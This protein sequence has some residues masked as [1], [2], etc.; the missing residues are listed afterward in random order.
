V[1][2]APRFVVAAATEQC[3]DSRM[4]RSLL[5]VMALLVV[6][7]TVAA[8]TLPPLAPPPTTPKKPVTDHY[9]TLSVVDDYRWL[10]D[11]R[12]PAVHAWADA[13]NERARKFLQAVPGREQ[14]AAQLTAI[15]SH[16]SPSY[17]DLKFCG[18]VI[19]A[20]K[21]EPP[22][23]QPG[24]VVRTSIDGDERMLIDPTRL[25]PSGA[26]AIDW[27]VPSRDGKRVALSLSKNGSERGDLHI[28]DVATG[29]ALPDVIPHVQNGTAG[30][31]AAFSSDGN[32]IFYTRYPRPGERPA[33]ELE[34]YQQVWFHK[35]GT[36][37]TSDTSQLGKELP[38]IAEIELSASRDGN[39]IIAAVENGDSDEF[40]F[41]LRGPDGKWLE[42]AQLADRIVSTTFG[43]GDDHSL[44]L[45]SRKD[46]PL[47]RVLRLPLATPTLAQA[48]V[49][50]PEGEGAIDSVQASDTRLWV[51]DLLGGPSRLRGFALDGKNGQ[52]VPT[53]PVASVGQLLALA[54]DELVF[55]VETNTAPPAWYRVSPSVPKPQLTSLRVTSPV[56]F[57][58]ITVTRATATSKD[59][60][61][62]PFTVLCKKGTRRDGKNPTVL[63]GYGGF[64][65]AE[66]P[67]FDPKLGPWLM[68]GGVW[69]IAN[70]RGGGEYGD[71][72]HKAGMLTHKQNVFDD[73]IAVAEELMRTRWT[74]AANLG[75]MGGSNGGLL[76]GAIVTQRPDLFRAVVSLVGI[77][78]MLRSEQTTNGQFN[79]T[80]YGSTKEPAQL[81]ALYGYSPYHHVVDGKKYPALFFATGDNDP[82]VDPMHSRKMVARMQAAS[83]S[84]SPILLR[85]SAKAGHGMGSSLDESIALDVDLQAFL[86]AELGVTLFAP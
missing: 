3:F 49:V 55:E 59:G 84:G 50:V 66:R 81:A 79:V 62:I 15:A 35:L 1:P 29:Q 74:S 20:R 22:K 54:G 48:T 25:D 19:F 78:D 68:S 69:V 4:K 58:G 44:Y 82:R 61:K 60:T 57:R 75:A 36:P 71:R 32:G 34:L 24:L 28:Y 7:G 72:W 37:P 18:G 70:L 30:G 51:T 14:L 64:G 41:F 80:E 39:W 46:A 73:F 86:F 83:L 63:Y 45:V 31:S 77:Y 21:R 5:V 17:F 56:D 47:G 11:G 40:A 38:R 33:A 53:P 10:E 9:G 16:R 13:Q 76:M 26:T 43:R 6:V 42:L 23:Q 8:M 12:D 27:Y 67:E 85:T 52:L 2:L 65:V